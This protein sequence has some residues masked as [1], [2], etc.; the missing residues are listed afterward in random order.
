MDRPK[1]RFTKMHGAGNDFVVVDGVRQR[2]RFTPDEWRRI[3]DRHLGVG[4]DQILL[5]ERSPREDVDFRYRIF[6]ADG[7]EVEQCGNGAR[8]FARFVLDHGLTER[9]AIRVETIGGIIEPAIEDDGRVRVDMGVPAFGPQAVGFDAAGVESDAVGD[10]VVW[11]LPV[12]DGVRRVSLVSLGN[13]H[14]VQFVDDV[15]EAPVRDEGPRI[16]RSR[17]FARGANAG[18]AQ[19]VSTHALRLRVWE[20]GAG[21]TLACGTGACAAA[22]AGIRQRRLRSPVDVHTRGG[23]LRIDWDETKLTLT[24]PARTVFEGEIDCAALFDTESE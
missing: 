15:D 11:M 6:N 8:C 16:E 9:R 5:V 2:V 21:E 20:R 18:F 3:A 1:L 7:A 19:V 24:G 17:R 13:P 4:A 22:L 14:A 10:D 12:G 23:L